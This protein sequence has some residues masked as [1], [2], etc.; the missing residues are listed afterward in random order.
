M[1]IIFE[2]LFGS[3]LYGTNTEGSDLD[4]RG[5]YVPSIDDFL[6]IEKIIEEPDLSIKGENKSTTLDRK[7]KS[8]KMFLLEAAEG[9]TQVLEMLF[10]P[11]NVIKTTSPA[12]EMIVAH[13]ELF[14]NKHTIFPFIAFSTSQVEKSIVK[15]ENLAIVR[16]VIEALNQERPNSRF[17]DAITKHD[18]KLNTLML[19]DNVEAVLLANRKFLTNQSVKEVRKKLISIEETFGSRTISTLEEGKCNRSLYHSYR[20]LFETEQMIRHGNLSF[21]LP[22]DQVDFLLKVK[23]GEYEGDF[24]D[25]ILTKCEELKALPS[26]HLKEVV[27][28]KFLNQLCIDVQKKALGL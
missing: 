5:V 4:Y 25:E 10:A 8:V 24:M 28:R 27:D 11:K 9:Q 12:W 2:T 6:G 18:L 19:Q 21:P 17:K 14:I 1:K 20:V 3:H 26:K 22:K 23:K 13:R 15:A 16:K 7:V